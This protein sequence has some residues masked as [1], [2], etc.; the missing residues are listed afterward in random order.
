M[1]L[2][3]ANVNKKLVIVPNV[4]E[5]KVTSRRN[6]LKSLTSDVLVELYLK[7]SAKSLNCLFRFR[8]PHVGQC[9]Y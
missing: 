6:Y 3:S 2:N 7:K 5:T 8:R 9:Q 4:Y 1:Q